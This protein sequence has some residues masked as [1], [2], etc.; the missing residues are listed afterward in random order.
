[1]STVFQWS[2]RKGEIA[3]RRSRGMKQAMSKM[4]KSDQD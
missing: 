1:M 4:M 3:E 2:R